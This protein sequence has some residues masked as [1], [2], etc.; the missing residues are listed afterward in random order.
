MMVFRKLPGKQK[1]SR[2]FQNKHINIWQ[3][4]LLGLSL[5]LA[6]ENSVKARSS[7]SPDLPCI[8]VNAFTAIAY[9]PL[10]G[11][12][13]RAWALPDLKSKELE[14]SISLSQIICPHP[15]KTIKVFL[16][17]EL[18]NIFSLLRAWQWI[19]RLYRPFCLGHNYPKMCA[20]V[21]QKQLLM[22]CKWIGRAMLQ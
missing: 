9:V 22:V 5:A 18:A 12:E 4:R 19:Y 11:E 16:R 17:W 7:L 6:L 8:L 21:V 13:T 14:T 15:G 2:H 20:V 3:C 10:F 1:P